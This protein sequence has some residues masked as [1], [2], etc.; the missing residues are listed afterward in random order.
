MSVLSPNTQLTTVSQFNA[1]NIIFGKPIANTIQA[2]KISY[3]QIKLAAKNADGSVGDLVIPTERLF[4]LG[5]KTNDMNGKPDNGYQLALIMHSREAPSDA[6]LAWIAMCNALVDH[7]KNH[8]MGVK[9]QIGLPDLTKTD[10]MFKFFNP[11]KYK[12]DELTKKVV[13]NRAPIMAPKLVMRK[14]EIVSLFTDERGARIDPMTL[15]SKQCH[16]RAAVKFEAIF[17]GESIITIQLKLYEAQVS[18]VD[19]QVR[20]LLAPVS[21]AAAAD[22]VETRSPLDDD[23]EFDDD[24][25]I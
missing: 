5:V 11:L 2:K 19:A 4:S 12:K 24:I 7:C 23:S 20:S 10:S 3:T 21:S 13:E 18:L 14:G 9:D 22:P 16:V 25:P 17:I 6:E 15:L 1:S 8:V